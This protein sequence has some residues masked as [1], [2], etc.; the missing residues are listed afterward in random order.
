MA[1][2]EARQAAA[3]AAASEQRR[4]VLLAPESRE[5]R[6]SAD[7]RPTS[8]K[9]RGSSQNFRVSSA[10]SSKGKSTNLGVSSAD[11]DSVSRASVNLRAHSAATSSKNKKRKGQSDVRRPKTANVA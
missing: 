4:I 3:V 5:R 10:D 11:S 2:R 1:L 9:R 6:P 7:G 8:G